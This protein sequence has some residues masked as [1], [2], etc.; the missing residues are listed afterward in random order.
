MA[1]N[2][3]TETAAGETQV[4]A[5]FRAHQRLVWGLGYRMLGSAMEAEDIVQEVM[6]KV[7]KFSAEQSEAVQNWEAWCMTLT[8]NRSLTAN[9]IRAVKRG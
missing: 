5:A 4:E 3:Q 9:S 7:W 6:E 8:R 1:G 2:T